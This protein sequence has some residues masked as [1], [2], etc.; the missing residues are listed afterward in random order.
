[1]KT[2]SKCKEIKNISEFHKN[3]QSK[4]GLKSSCKICRNSENS[5]TRNNNKEY[6]K[7]YYINNKEKLNTYKK[8]WYYINSETLKHNQKEYYSNNKD[9]INNRNSVY[10][11]ENKEIISKYQKKYYISN[12]VHINE[13]K[14]EYFNN[15]YKNNYT[16]KLKCS[17]SSLIRE[18]IKSKG[19]NKKSKSVDILGCSIEEFKLH[20]ESKFESWM[21][22]D[23]KGLY[24]GQFN[25]GWDIDHIIPIS[26]GNTEDE[27]IKLNNYKN[28]QP[29]CS[30]INRDIKRDKLEY[31]MD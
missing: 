20:L 30:K 22:W 28:L 16:F 2:C 24:N 11:K 19:F 14:K 8:E 10:N 15:K 12:R 21:T 13:Y 3:K 5:I 23:N 29:L 26:S 7:E 27:V 31:E 4:D 9:Y 6:F 17:I 25:Y 1:M 18:S